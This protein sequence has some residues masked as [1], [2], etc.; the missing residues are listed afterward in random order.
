MYLF[1]C[2]FLSLKID[3]QNCF[4]IA[5]VQQKGNGAASTNRQVIV[6]RSSFSCNG[7]VTGYLISL[8]SDGSSGGYP[9]V[10]VWH[11]TSSTEYT[12]VDTECPLTASDISMMNAN[13]DDYYLG[14]VSCSGSNR[15]EF[16]SGDVIG[17]HHGSPV[18][19]QLR[20]VNT[21][22][23][24]TYRYST[25]SPLD[26]FIIE[27]GTDEDSNRQPLIQVVYGKINTSSFIKEISM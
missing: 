2:L 6:P 18:L 8:E 21:D 5:N 17:Y 20:L 7:R 1:N 10:Q 9:S 13:G 24:T 12:R 11:P 27:S 22:G 16:Q 4:D 3:G 15:I 26:T 19:Y 25:S 23:Y 14:N